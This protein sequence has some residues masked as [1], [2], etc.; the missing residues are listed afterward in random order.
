MHQNPMILARDTNLDERSVTIG[1]DEILDDFAEELKIYYTASEDDDTLDQHPYVAIIK[2][3]SFSGKTAF[4][5]HLFDELHKVDYWQP[6]LRANR[7]KLPIF[8]SHINS[9][10]KL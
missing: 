2:G 3:E 9:E 10:N 6:Y 8:V 4:I 7:N 5:K 1:W